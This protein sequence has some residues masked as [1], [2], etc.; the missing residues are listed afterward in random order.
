MELEGGG[1]NNDGQKRGDVRREK[2]RETGQADP[3]E[4]DRE[5]KFIVQPFDLGWRVTQKEGDVI[6]RGKRRKER[7]DLQIQQ[8]W[9][10]K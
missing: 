1:G 10:E 8:R 4:M 3:A 2:G 5:T 6:N 9:T 7:Q